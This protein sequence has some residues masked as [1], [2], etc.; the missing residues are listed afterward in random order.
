MSLTHCLSWICHQICTSWEQAAFTG[1]K[2]S[3]SAGCSLWHGRSGKFRKIVWFSV[4]NA[5]AARVRC[6]TWLSSVNNA[7]S[8][9]VGQTC[10]AKC[11][12]YSRN[13]YEFTKINSVTN[14][15]VPVAAFVKVQGATHN[16]HCV[17]LCS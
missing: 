2:I 14:A 15:K 10:H 9:L 8:S 17:N 7:E 6:E 12:D 4:Q 11:C 1:T 13:K 16:C 5:T 3:T